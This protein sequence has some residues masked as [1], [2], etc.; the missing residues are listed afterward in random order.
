[1][2]FYGRRAASE[3]DG[4]FTIIQIPDTQYY[5]QS[6]PAILSHQMNWIVANREAL[7]VRYVAHCGDVVQL[8]TQTYQWVNADAA[9]ALLE[10]PVTTMLEDG[11]PYGVLPGNHDQTP[12]GNPDGTTDYNAWFGVARFLGRDYYGG[13]YPPQNNDNNYGFF[14]GGGMD[15]I[16]INLEYDTSPDLDVLDWADALLKT[17]RDRRAIVV[18]H[19]LMNIGEGASFG[20]QG[21]MTYDALKNNANLFLMLCGHMHGEG[22]RIDVYQGRTVYTLLADYQDLPNGGNGW[23]RILE[24]SPAVDEIRV[25]TYSPWLDAYGTD[26]VMGTDTTSA[27]FTIPYDMP[28]G[29]P[30]R[31]I[32]TLTDVARDSDVSMPWPGQ[33]A[34][35]TYEWY[36]DVSDGTSTT[37]SAVWTFTSDGTCGTTADCDDGLFC[38]GSETCPPGGG[39]CTPGPEPC[40]SGELCDEGSDTCLECLENADCDDGNPCTGAEQC[41]GGGCVPGTPMDCS[42]LDDPC[43]LGTCNPLTGLCESQPA[44]EGMG[45]DDGLDCTSQDV[46]EEGTCVGHDDCPD[47][48][49]CD[50]QTGACELLPVWQ[51]FREGVDG[52]TGMRDTFLR[53]ATPTTAQG[54][55]DWVEWDAREGS[56]NQ[57][58]LALMRF[59]GLFGVGA[60]Q[61][62]LEARV[63]SAMLTLTVRNAGNEGILSEALVDWDESTTYATFGGEPGAQPDEYGLPITHV[64]GTTGTH[65]VDVTQSLRTWMSDPTAN[66]G[67]IVRHTGTDG[68]EVWSSDGTTVSVRPRLAVLYSILSTVDGDFDR[69]SDVDDTDYRA[70]ADCLSGPGTAPQPL[71]ASPLACMATFDFDMDSDVD[72]ADG[73]VLTRL[74]TGLIPPGDFDDDGDVDLTD[75][76]AFSTCLTGPDTGSPPAADGIAARCLLVFDTDQ[77]RDVDLLDFGGFQELL[78]L[79]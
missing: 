39:V 3:A 33:A 25:T 29:L 48:R 63:D 58:T 6:Y 57:E 77:D 75:Y 42:G 20:T 43:N 55:R 26:A 12:W 73:H 79:P 61:V 2:T 22:R 65:T 49:V 35:T 31:P 30:F 13:H 45:C 52:Y 72:L 64:P 70:F 32:G 7:N 21:Q 5:S 69:D 4:R 53:E 54:G 23:L 50:S 68:V 37:S 38:N 9:M 24:F 46:C 34:D 44:N 51:S 15:F 56:S 36:V 41:E 16:V 78:A 67:W 62:P 59:D 47:G 66:L 74:Y 40:P 8:A 1:V 71:V 14:R 60:G 76:A 17:N 10:D 19:Y 11:I 28:E 27:V 18:G